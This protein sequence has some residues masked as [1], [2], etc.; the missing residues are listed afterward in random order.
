LHLR[1]ACVQQN[2]ELVIEKAGARV[3]LLE[4]PCQRVCNLYVIGWVREAENLDFG[5]HRLGQADQFAHQPFTIGEGFRHRQQYV[6][7][8]Y[9]RIL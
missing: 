1:R 6:P 3:G 9:P 2:V 7:V 5:L 8:E 4:K